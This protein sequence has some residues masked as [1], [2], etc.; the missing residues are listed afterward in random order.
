MTVIKPNSVAG[1]NSIT[2][3]SGEAL[4]VHKSDGS[5]IKTIVSASGVSTFTS[6]SV[7]AATTDNNRDASINIGLGASISQ[8]TV[9]S[10]SLG[11]G[12]SE[13]LS[14]TS[15]GDINIGSVGRFDAS[16]LVK[17][18]HGTESAPSH[19]FLND[20]DNG[21]Y[22]PT[23]N[24]LGFVCGGDEK[25][26]ITSGGDV[27]VGNDSPNCRLAVKDTATHTA[28]A[29]LTPSVGSC[30]LQLYNNPSSEAVNNHSTLQF[31]VY[32]GS[33]NRVNT[34]SA[35]AESASNR[36]MAL[37]FCTD[38]GANRNERMRI[39]GDGSIGVGTATPDQTLEIH[40]VSG[41]N[42]YKASTQANSTVGLEIEKTG[43]TTQS[44][45][46][47]DGQTVNGAL[48][49]YDVTDSATRLL[50]DG[51]GKINIGGDFS[52]STRQ[53]SVVSSVEQV[54]TFEYSGADADGSEVRF[55]H[56]SSSP[57]DDDTLAFLQFSGKNSADEVTLYSG[58]TAESSDVTNGTED[59]NIIFSTRAAGSFG[60]RLRITSA[61]LVGIATAIPRAQFDVIKDTGNVIA[62]FEGSNASQNHRVRIDASGASSTSALSISNSNSNNQTSM[63]HSGGNNNMVIMGGQTAGAEPTAGTAVATFASGG[64]VTVNTGNL[65][66]GTSGKGID[67]SATSDGGNGTPSE[68]LDDYE[69]GTWT[70][71]L[72]N[73]GGFG[74]NNTVGTYTKVGRLV[75]FIMQISGVRD[76][77][78][79]SGTFYISGLPFAADN[80]TGGHGQAGCMGAL[81][82]WNIPNTAYQIGIRVADNQSYIQL[83]ANFDNAAD[84][85]LSTP[86]D[87][88]KTIFG[89]LAGSY[90]TN[91]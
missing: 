11:T 34:I 48:E 68:L 32:G 88:N 42:L 47:V 21:M 81:Y 30:M 46:I 55:Y 13:K 54:A 6:A 9:N 64:D 43:A 15:G 28:Y 69:E 31:G 20:P 78:S 4:S 22:R 58:I 12:G 27:G 59:G 16:G 24:T 79:A 66:I 14:I 71:V 7:G 90:H 75:T 67:F 41:T 65:V 38:S 49:I 19:T 37:T 85:Q 77:S 40:T 89:S 91:S 8:H 39:T 74:T 52:Q 60:E 76:S 26:R 73:A 57:A 2:V 63:Y 29:G 1:I 17:S 86:F 83:F 33:H 51:S 56:N 84:G 87:A 62:L 61:G 23:T 45:R 5:L 3:Q 44:W 50:V 18:A 70:P 10:L 82:N 36:K 72:N 53:L 80:S 35:V 25:L